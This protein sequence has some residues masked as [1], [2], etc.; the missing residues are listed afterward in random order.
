MLAITRRRRD[1]VTL[2]VQTV[3]SAD[4]FERLRGPYA[5]MMAEAGACSPFTTHRWL[6]AW[7][8]AFA[9]DQRVRTFAVW[10]DRTLVAAFPMMFARGRLGRIPVGRAYLLGDGWGLIDPPTSLPASSWAGPFAQWLLDDPGARWMTLRFGPSLAS[11]VG[12]EPFAEQLRR[13]GMPLRIVERQNPFLRLSASW[14]EFLGGRSRNFRRTVKRKERQLSEPPGFRMR[15]TTAPDL[16]EVARTVFGVSA[17]SWQGSRGVAVAS[18]EAGRR[19]YELLTRGRDDFV[20]HLT[21]IDTDERC[22]GYLVGL[23]RAGAYH[24]FDTGYDPRYSDLSPGLLLHL[25]AL[26]ES[27][28]REFREF[29][30]GL[31]HPYK[32]RFEPEMRTSHDVVA[33]RS[34]IIAGIDRLAEFARRASNRRLGAPLEASPS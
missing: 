18:T 22:V 34:R 12:G 5:A 15:H 4:D 1:N 16:E 9:G 29:N 32:E 30:F 23:E 8:R 24:A 13:R 26:R 31:D 6:L 14:Q 10:C 21:T 28:G 33:F 17:V 19:F 3:E 2:H 27:C 11:P 20:L 25:A 7:W